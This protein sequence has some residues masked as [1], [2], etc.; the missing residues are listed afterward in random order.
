MIRIVFILFLFLLLFIPLYKLIKYFYLFCK[1]EIDTEPNKENVEEFKRKK[2]TL[3]S[4]LE[5]KQKELEKINK[6]NDDLISELK[7]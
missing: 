3:V 1:V 6:I 2:K 7:K 5:K 4:D